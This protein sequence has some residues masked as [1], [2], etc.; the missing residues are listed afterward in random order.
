MAMLVIKVRCPYCNYE[1]TTTTLKRVRCWNCLRYFKVLYYDK[2]HNIF[3]T[4][5][6]DIVKGSK[7]M[8]NSE[9]ARVKA[10]CYRSRI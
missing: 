5:I 8:L 1:F 9:I 2:K 7:E 6:V 10:E 3:R 4:R